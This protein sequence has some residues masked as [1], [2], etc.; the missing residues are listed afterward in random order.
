[1]R[2]RYLAAFQYGFTVPGVIAPA[3]AA[4]LAVAVWLPWLLA[5]LSAGLAMLVLGWLAGRLPAAALRPA[6]AGAG[7]LDRVA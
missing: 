5:G 2:G 7:T 4:L 6:V 1:V 3:I